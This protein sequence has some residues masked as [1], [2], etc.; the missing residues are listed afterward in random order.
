MYY[1]YECMV[2]Y[3]CVYVCVFCA[4]VCFDAPS[5]LVL[6]VNM[7]VGLCICSGQHHSTGYRVST[8]ALLVMGS[9]YP[10]F[11]FLSESLSLFMP[12]LYLSGRNSKLP[13]VTQA[14][15]HA[16]SERYRLQITTYLIPHILELIHTHTNTHT[17][18]HKNL[19]AC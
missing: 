1:V 6:S 9:N 13:K 15:R 5:L 8:I 17:D 12:T 14:K 3:M 11:Q 10:R 7:S 4:C 19:H 16:C 18:T 2:V